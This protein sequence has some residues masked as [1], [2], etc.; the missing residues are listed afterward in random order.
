MKRKK[1]KELYATLSTPVETFS[2]PGEL[3]ND[4][5]KRVLELCDACIDE[6]TFEMIANKENNDK[7]KS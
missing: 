1:I 5:E 6:Y 7:L 4:Q 3:I 2:T